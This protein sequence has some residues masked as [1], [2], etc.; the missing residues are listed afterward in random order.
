MVEMKNLL[1]FAVLMLS[2][3]VHGER[4]ATMK[5]DVS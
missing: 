1:M 4:K 5:Q 2:L 3:S